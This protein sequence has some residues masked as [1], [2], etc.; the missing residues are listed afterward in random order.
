MATGRQKNGKGAAP[1]PRIVD[2]IEYLIYINEQVSVF[3]QTALCNCT[4]LRRFPPLIRLQGDCKVDTL[5]LELAETG[6]IAYFISR[7]R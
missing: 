5:I 2:Q 3:D 7:I 6:I 1:D 4:F